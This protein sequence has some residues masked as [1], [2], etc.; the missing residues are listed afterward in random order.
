MRGDPM[1]VESID[2]QSEPQR[3]AL[4]LDKPWLESLFTVRKVAVTKSGQM[5]SSLRM[6]HLLSDINE[7]SFQVHGHKQ[8]RRWPKWRPRTKTVQRSFRI[9]LKTNLKSRKNRHTSNRR[10]K[11]SFMKS[12]FR[13]R[14]TQTREKFESKSSK[15]I[16]LDLF[17]VP[18]FY[19]GTSRTWDG[20]GVRKRL[21]TKLAEAWWVANSSWWSLRVSNALGYWFFHRH[22]KQ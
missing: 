16:F 6:N 2:G 19:E 10:C 3:V 1:Q 18:R 17:S 15:H 9:A 14:Q 22:E 4:L 8:S 13:V 5:S 7:I 11:E 21:Q 12:S 20:G